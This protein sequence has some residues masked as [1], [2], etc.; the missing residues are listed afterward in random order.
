M[1]S[2]KRTMHPELRDAATKGDEFYNKF[3]RKLIS[4]GDKFSMRKCNW[5]S[6]SNGL[7]LNYLKSNEVI[8]QFYTGF[9]KPENITNIGKIGDYVEAWIW[10]LV[11]NYGEEKAKEYIIKQL[12]RIANEK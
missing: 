12:K 9:K 6:Q 1:A 2:N 11:V 10:F 5:C 8:S 7:L 3:I 4:K